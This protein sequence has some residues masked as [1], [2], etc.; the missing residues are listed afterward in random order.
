MTRIEISLSRAHK[1]AERLK[2]QAADLSK[3][4]LSQ[5][6][7]AHIAGITG[8]AHIQRLSA[9]GDKAM[10]L[11]AKSERYL[12]V[13]AEVRT[14]IARENEARG[15]NGLLARLDVVNRLVTQ[16]KELLEQAKSDGIEP[17]ELATYKPLMGSEARSYSSGVAVNVLGQVRREALESALSQLQREAVQLSDRIAEANA[18]RLALELDEDIALEVTGG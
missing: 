10:A 1:I 12:R 11:S 15:I 7:T 13:M 16:K 5:A 8:E 14:V 2:T 18:A 17:M 3:E 6:Q 9:Q 4:A